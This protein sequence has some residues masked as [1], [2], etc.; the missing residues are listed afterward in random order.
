MKRTI[1]LALALAALV[2][3]CATICKLPVVGSLPGCP[4]PAPTAV[5]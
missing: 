1:I 3:G 5:P 2:A 4:T